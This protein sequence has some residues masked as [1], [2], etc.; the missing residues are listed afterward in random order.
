MRE[1]KR[2]DFI[3]LREGSSLP[4]LSAS[5]LVC[6]S[7]SPIYRENSA[8]LIRIGREARNSKLS[9]EVFS[10]KEETEFPSSQTLFPQPS[11]NLLRLI[12]FTFE[13]M[14]NNAEKL[15]CD[16]TY[17]YHLGFPLGEEMFVVSRESGVSF[18]TSE[19]HIVSDC[20]E[21][22]IPLLR[23]YS[24]LMDRGARDKLLGRKT[25]QF[26]QCLRGVYRVNI[27]QLS[28]ES[29]SGSYI[30]SIND[31]EFLSERRSQRENG[32]R[33]L[34]NLSSEEG[35]SLDGSPDEVRSGFI[36][37]S[38]RGF[39]KVE[40][41]LCFSPSK[42]FVSIIFEEGSKSVNSKL[43]Y[44]LWGRERGKDS[45]G[46]FREEVREEGREFR[47]SFCE[48]RAELDFFSGEL[49]C[50]GEVFSVE[51]SK[52]FEGTLRESCFSGFTISEDFS[53]SEGVEVIEL[54]RGWVISDSLMEGLF[55]GDDIEGE[56]VFEDCVSKRFPIWTCRFKNEGGRGIGEESS[57]FNLG[58]ESLKTFR[59]IWE[60]EV[61]SDFLSIAH[62]L[63]MSIM[64]VLMNIQAH[65]QYIFSTHK[66]PPNPLLKKEGLA[67]EDCL[68]STN[69]LLII[70]GIK[71]R[72]KSL[73]K[74]E[75]NFLHEEDKYVENE[76]RIINFFHPYWSRFYSIGV[77]PS[78][79]S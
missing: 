9:N 49:F 51:G 11:S 6:A 13:N 16:C 28:Y 53:Y 12:T 22:W 42:D 37:N 73:P 52:L 30:N 63:E 47:V 1:G 79:Y 32:G 40:E 67:R 31:C 35:Y 8:D 36:R 69:P 3:S 18:N 50:K 41:F 70:T 14:E 54:R 77:F 21:V 25:S 10:S 74:E 33:D 7:F 4:E 78:T 58:E 20:S 61:F 23:D 15:S 64:G 2:L 26:H 45:E 38:Y 29:T 48:D 46:D 66:K 72:I 60:G 24:F 55:R 62:K 5:I 56:G 68:L 59:R 34:F 65:N 39:H 75:I 19:S 27:S 76:Q 71:E 57:S 44:L 17:C 43:H